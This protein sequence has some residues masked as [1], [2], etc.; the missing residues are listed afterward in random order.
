MDWANSTAGKLS[1]VALYSAAALLKKRR[2]AAI[3]F[4]RSDS[5]A[6]QLLEVLVGLE[7]GIGLGQGEDLAQRTLQHPLGRRL[8][9]G[10]L[11]ARRPR[12]GP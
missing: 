7:V 9:G 2:E 10:P 11:R 5:S 3:L 12:C 8:G 4:S 6:L 1:R